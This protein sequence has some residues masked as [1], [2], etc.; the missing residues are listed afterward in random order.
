MT[1]TMDSIWYKEAIK[2]IPCLDGDSQWVIYSIN[3]GKVKLSAKANEEF[4]P[5]NK[6]WQEYLKE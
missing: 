1:K 3:I 4:Q 2:Q 6:E 5:F